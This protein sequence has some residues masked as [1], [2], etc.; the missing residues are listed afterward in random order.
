MSTNTYSPSIYANPLLYALFHKPDP[1]SAIKRIRAYLQEQ[2]SFAKNI[3]VIPPPNVIWSYD[4][5]TRLPFSELIMTSEDFISSHILE[6]PQDAKSTDRSRR[7]LTLNKKT[8]F[9]FKNFIQTNAGFKLHFNTTIVDETIISPPSP[10]FPDDT[11]FL[12]YQVGYPLTGKPIFPNLISQSP[13]DSYTLPSPVSPQAFSSPGSKK[14]TQSQ[15]QIQKQ[16]EL[17]SKLIDLPEYFGIDIEKVKVDIKLKRDY[18]L[19]PLAYPKDISKSD[20]ELFNIVNTFSVENVQTIDELLNAY[21]NVIDKAISVFSQMGSNSLTKIMSETGLSSHEIGQ[22]VGE[23]V[24]SQLHQQ[25]WE[26][27]LQFHQVE[28]AKTSDLCWVMK[29]ISV[30]QLGIPVKDITTLFDLDDL[31]AQSVKLF[32]SITTISS[33]T[34]KIKV[35]LSVVQILTNGTPDATDKETLQ[36]VTKCS[37]HYNLE[38][39]QDKNYSKLKN[40]IS[41]DI[42][43]SLMILVVVRSD[44]VN[45]NSLLFYIRNFSFVDVDMGHLGYSLSTL[46]AVTYH[47]SSN[48]QKLT[49]LSRLNKAFMSSLSSLDSVEAFVEKLKE[50]HPKDWKSVIRSRSPQGASALVTAIQAKDTMSLVE[51]GKKHTP[52]LLEYLFDLTD[53]NGE[54]IFDIDYTIGD[55]DS[56][57]FSLFLLALDTEDKDFIFSVLGKIDPL[58]DQRMADYFARV[59]NWKR[60]VGHYIFRAHWLIPEIGHLIDWNQKD[61]AGQTPLFALCRCYDHQNYDELV[62]LAFKAWEAKSIAES[63]SKDTQ[64]LDL[65]YHRDPKD[66]TLLHIVKD[67]IPVKELLRFNIDVNWP[68]EAGF[69]P[70]MVYS[71]FSR[72]PAIKAIFN[73]P[74]VDIYLQ[75]EGGST[76]LE[77][78]KEDDTT[79]YLESAYISIDAKSLKGKSTS[80]LRTSLIKGR[81]FFIITTGTPN[82]PNDVV[83]IRRTFDDF[84]FLEKWLSYENPYSWVPPLYTIN[85]PKILH[86]KTVYQLFH[87]IQTRLNC[88]LRTLLM[89]PTFAQHELLWE[90]IL[91]QD[92][93]KD[94]IIERCRRKL[95]SHQETQMEREDDSD[96]SREKIKPEFF[97]YRSEELDPILYFMQY[98]HEQLSKLAR[99]AETI[100][101]NIQKIKISIESYNSS[102]INFYQMFDKFPLGPTETNSFKN[103]TPAQKQPYNEIKS[104]SSSSFGLKETNAPSLDAYFRKSLVLGSTI[105]T[106]HYTDFAISCDALSRT[107][108][109]AADKLQ[110]PINMIDQLKERESTLKSL[111]RSLEKASGK[112]V[113]PMAIFEE[114]RAKDINDM[115]DQIYICQNEINRLSKDI[116]RSHET[117]ASEVGSLYTIHESELKQYIQKFSAR[118]IKSNKTQ[119]GRLQR[120]RTQFGRVWKKEENTP[121]SNKEFERKLENSHRIKN[122]NK[123]APHHESN[124]QVLNEK[125]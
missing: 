99:T 77:I 40:T 78:A 121:E 76:A 100:S 36:R 2:N 35:L 19:L 61:L 46:E 27:T 75:G 8:V 69:T 105:S 96:D 84:K 63:S 82:D 21:N 103:S 13:F 18:K 87:E 109:S 25:L 107:V 53:E 98:A 14:N 26:K 80:I 68:N 56:S 43:V 64:D 74:R 89:H 16:K 45:I 20:L 1:S 91:V 88:F 5:E 118:M 47:I 59:N 117:L 28:D 110:I 94:S 7:M 10:F 122:L 62:Q 24:E 29:N 115:N 52:E 37:V 4:E 6:I 51:S 44:M 42:L 92:L 23:H 90:F 79:K 33:V 32:S 17:D 106:L 12:V 31:V 83:S 114:K 39:H 49:K 54:E 50:K 81:I 30:E 71:K 86:G 101:K 57:G 123:Y 120:V 72:L 93:S 113:W 3:I 95:Q 22:M 38:L 9:V 102:Q 15:E 124:L 67:E 73:D 112:N 66:N 70:L 97:F 104:Q 125:I 108:S 116:N 85:G 55:R 119:L 11:K 111:H 41:A 65:M 60:S 48:H 58:D 34:D